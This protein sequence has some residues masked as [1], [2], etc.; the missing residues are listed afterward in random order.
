[1]LLLYLR[2]PRQRTAWIT[3]YIPLC[4]YFIAE[5]AQ[6]VAEEASF[7]FHYASTLSVRFFNAKILSLLFTFHYASTLSYTVQSGD[8]LSTIFTFHY[9][10]TLS[11][12]FETGDNYVADICLWYTK[13]TEKKR[14]NSLK[15]AREIP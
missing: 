7:T 13:F 5:T 6:T 14:Q 8:C 11:E 12:S 15:K 9:A 3:I 1:M 2:F 4:F 10:S